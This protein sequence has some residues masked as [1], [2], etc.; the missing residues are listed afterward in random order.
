MKASEGEN[1]FQASHCRPFHFYS[2]VTPLWQGQRLGGIGCLLTDS[3][4]VKLFLEASA[5]SDLTKRQELLQYFSSLQPPTSR[6][7]Q[8]AFT[9]RLGLPQTGIYNK[10]F[11]EAKG[12]EWTIQVHNVWEGAEREEKWRKREGRNTQRNRERER[13]RRCHLLCG[14]SL[15]LPAEQDGPALWTP[16]P[17]PRQADKKS[18]VVIK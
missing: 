3:W 10:G 9:G 16:H 6:R 18:Q 5:L 2:L 7:P 13:T 4:Q 17:R 11:L 8:Q 14:V 12:G 15:W 1:E